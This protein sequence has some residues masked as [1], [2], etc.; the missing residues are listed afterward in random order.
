MR[1]RSSAESICAM[2]VDNELFLSFQFEQQ[3]LRKG[4]L[5]FAARRKSKDDFEQY[6]DNP[7]LRWWAATGG[8]F[9]MSDWAE[10]GIEPAFPLDWHY[11][12]DMRPSPM[13]R[14][15]VDA[16]V[17]KV[18]PEMVRKSFFYGSPEDIAAEII[19]FVKQGSNLN[20]IA[21]LSPLMME[22]DPFDNIKKLAEVCRLVKAG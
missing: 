9:K 2:T 4:I 5:I 16:I 1:V 3:S 10:E 20:L 7:M 6:V 12:F 21:D 18:T 15:E 19:P 14:A 11:A 17:A 8:R 13:S 22:I